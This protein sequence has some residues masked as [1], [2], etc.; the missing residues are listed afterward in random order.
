MET[1]AVRRRG[2]DVR[3]NTD[4]DGFRRIRLWTGRQLTALGVRAA[5]SDALREYLFHAER[6]VVAHAEDRSTAVLE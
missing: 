1:W 2:R 5:K 3:R 6:E 4:I